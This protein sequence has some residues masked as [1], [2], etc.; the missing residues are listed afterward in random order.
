[1]PAPLIWFRINNGEWNGSPTANPSTRTG[2]IDVSALTAPFFPAAYISTGFSGGQLLTFNFGASAFAQTV[3][4]GGVAWGAET[5]LNPV[6]KN[7][8]I[9][10][11]GGNL[12]MAAGG[13]QTGAG[14]R[15]TT[16][17]ATKN[18]LRY[19]E[20]VMVT[21]PQGWF[22][23][24]ASGAASLSIGFDVLNPAEWAVVR[25][26]GGT[27]IDGS[28][29]NGVF[30]ALSAGDVICVVTSVIPPAPV[31]SVNAPVRVG[32][33]SRAMIL[34]TRLVA[35][36]WE[37]IP[38]E[39]VY[40]ITGGPGEGQVLINTPEPSSTW[41]P[42]TT[43][44]QADINDGYLAYQNTGTVV[45]TDDFTFSIVDGGSPATTGTLDVIVMQGGDLASSQPTSFVSDI[46]HVPPDAVPAP[47]SLALDTFS[48][49]GGVKQ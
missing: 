44:T 33:G 36:G 2:G 22:V 21:A 29:S 43:F 47:V 20:A 45:G 12:S 8:A 11:S 4:A 34:P 26:D 5:T 6:D 3:P 23:G 13:E 17:S 32:V 15:A 30:P 24:V 9:A 7:A 28:G 46:F 18:G 48:V 14:A 16:S 19:F 31:I 41:T 40:T 1:M 38:A 37:G 49:P 35:T 10:L 27:N 42:T 25:N 39:V